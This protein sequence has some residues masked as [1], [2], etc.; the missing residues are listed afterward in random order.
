MR[1]RIYAGAAMV[2]VA[3]VRTA[4]AVRDLSDSSL[5]L[6]LTRG[7]GWIGVLGALLFGIV[8][9]NVISLSLNAGSGRIGQQVAELERENSALRAELAEGLTASAVE[10]EAER[11]GLA[12]PDPE[13]VGYLTVHDGDVEHLAELLDKDTFLSSPSTYE[14]A[15]I[16]PSFGDPEPSASEPAP[17]P[18]SPAPA[19]SPPSGESSGGGSTGGGAAPSA[20]GGVGL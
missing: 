8:A 4:G 1:P 14:P 15:A 3:A 10:G 13:D 12:V 5:I 6:Q 16:A 19:S 17:A 18:S 11:L 20:S 9:L 7:R 2:P